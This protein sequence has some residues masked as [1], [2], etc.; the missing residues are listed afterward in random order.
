MAE[1]TTK[2]KNRKA[3]Q[4][5]SKQAE[6]SELSELAKIL[7]GEAALEKKN[8]EIERL[9][10]EAVSKQKAKQQ[11]QIKKGEVVL[12]PEQYL[13]EEAQNR[14]KVIQK[15]QLYSW[16][17]PI[18]TKFAFDKKTFLIIVAVALGFILY[19]AVLGQYGL[20]FAI[21]ALLFFIYVAG[22]TEPITVEHSITTRGID[23]MDKLYEWYMLENF[24]F[25]KK[26]GQHVLIVTTR[27]RIPAQ[28]IM[29]VSPEEMSALFVLLQDKLLYRDV[30]KQGRIERTTFGDYVP[31]E[32]I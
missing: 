10:L 22:T 12:D 27:L 30:R 23:S 5:K 14:N 28:L 19:L 6:S 2:D 8:A 21:M 17:A 20:M 13:D 31:M 1:K 7:S 32:S 11:Q 18:R 25:A 3:D 4:K 9:K 26:N 29:L 24:W 15:I 16:E